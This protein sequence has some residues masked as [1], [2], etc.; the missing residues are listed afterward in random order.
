MKQYHLGE[1]TAQD[2]L[3]KLMLIRAAIV[4]YPKSMRWKLR[5]HI[6][7]RLAWR[8]EVEMQNKE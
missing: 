4:T 7:T 2:V 1:E 6:G 5:S 8:K 3:K